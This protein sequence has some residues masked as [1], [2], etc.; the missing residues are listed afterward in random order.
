MDIFRDIFG[1]Q[2]GIFTYASTRCVQHTKDRAVNLLQVHKVFK[3]RPSCTQSE[4][5]R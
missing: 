5:E 2:A 3:L 4:L 1:S